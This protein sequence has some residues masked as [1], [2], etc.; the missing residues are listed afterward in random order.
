MS[1]TLSF[2][3]KPSPVSPLLLQRQKSLHFLLLCLPQSIYVSSRGCCHPSSRSV[4]PLQFSSVWQYPLY[5]A[6]SWK[7]QGTDRRTDGER[8][9]QRSPWGFLTLFLSL[10]LTLSNQI[11]ISLL[12]MRLL[13]PSSSL[14]L[15]LSVPLNLSL[16]LFA[17]FVSALSFHTA[18]YLTQPHPS[19]HHSPSVSPAH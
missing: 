13:D 7:Q 11:S 3:F 17:R 10:T 19:L 15:S 1:S 4:L 9:R 16:F 5:L 12:L 2:A 18:H 8:E 14:F 6:A